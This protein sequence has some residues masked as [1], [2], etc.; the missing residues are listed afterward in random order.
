MRF[1]PGDTVRIA[2]RPHEGHHRTP[3]YVK[4]RIGRIER[5]HASFLNPE[6]RA[7]GGGGEPAEQLYLVGFELP[8]LWSEYRGGDT[9]RLL[10]DVFE[11][12]LEPAA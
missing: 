7:Y 2:D 9:D 5:A 3:G 10:V 8:G 12:W 4:G 11:H 6:T 1:A